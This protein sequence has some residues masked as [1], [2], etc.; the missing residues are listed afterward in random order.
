MVFAMFGIFIT[1]AVYGVI[2][3]DLSI[4]EMKKLLGTRN[5]VFA[6]NM[7]QD[8]DKYIDKRF[9]DFK[10]L[11]KATVVQES[12][13]KS[14]SEFR[15]SI[16]QELL[17]NQNKTEAE[18]DKNIEPFIQGISDKELTSDLLNIIEFYN[19]EYGYNVVE[20]LFITNAFGANV[21]LGSG[22]SDY[23][24]DDEE[25]W[26]IAKN[27]G[28][29]VGNL[30]FREQYGNYATELGFRIDDEQG[31]FLGVLR[32]VLTLDD[33][34]HEFINDAELINLPNR[35]GILLDSQGRI[36]YSQGIQDFS[37][38]QPVDYFDKILQGKEVGTI[39]IT[40]RSDDAKIISYAKSTGYK[41][42]AGFDWVTVVNQASSSFI[43][44]FIDLRNSILITSIIGMISSIVIGI[45]VSF[46]ITNPLKDLS[47]LAESISKG[48]FNVKAGKSKINE[49]NVIGNSF[50]EM[51]GSLQKLIETEKKLAETQ[52]RMKNERL[53][54]IGE[55][56][57]S[58][59]HNMK[60]PLG[61]IRSSAD[62]VKRNAMGKSQELDEVLSRMDRAIER[63]SRQIEDVLNFVRVSPLI[64]SAVSLKSLLNGAVES[65]DIPKNIVVQLPQTDL[66][67]R[68]DPKKIEIVFIN[69]ILNSL[70]AIGNNQGIIRIQVREENN[71]AIIEVEDSG[72]GIPEEV[73]P[74][75]F[76]ALVTTK[77]KGTGLGLSTCK[78]IIE[79]HEGTISAKNNPT[80]FTIRI[81][82]KNN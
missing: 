35:N 65:I 4:Q 73:F 2:T 76:G 17:L 31:N 53:A 28:I 19:N 11:A 6:F 5:E 8:L 62:I 48:K 64:T 79:Q 56:A 52:V 10:E 12:L 67:L 26:Q 24:Q 82:L 58:M 34:I 59:A 9:T 43:D 61:T 72:P 20:E 44:E 71:F 78:N 77:E 49:I 3:F 29:F 30:E 27:T 15:N 54:G 36:I 68:C 70:Q 13:K 42:F 75:I 45:V 1:F 47:R 38:L 74:K 46:F 18:N 51:T 40:D 80:T 60:N 37:N 69:L 66:Q 57:A 39:E 55:I 81:P 23:R 25:W 41:T 21:A 22:T 63:M 14:N 7:M 32:V 16:N 50:N 33:I